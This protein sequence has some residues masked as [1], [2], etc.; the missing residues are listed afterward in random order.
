MKARLIT[1]E[2]EEGGTAVIAIDGVEL[3]AMDCLGYGTSDQP[4]PKVGD[5]F[6]PYFTCLFDD[7]ESVDWK[8]VFEANPFEEQRLESIGTWS[9]RAYGKL[10]QNDGP[11]EYLFADCGGPL[12]PL[13]IDV[14]G[15]EKIGS[16][17]GFNIMRL[18]V[19]LA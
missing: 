16:F 9:Y 17:V 7:N 2:D 3:T 10:V 15:D 6:K 11:D 5:Y 12:L 13:P 18:S 8:A 4:Y 14:F 19:W 1:V